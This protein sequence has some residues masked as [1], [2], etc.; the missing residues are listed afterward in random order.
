[1]LIA[2]GE[3]GGPAAVVHWVHGGGHL[4][5]GWLHPAEGYWAAHPGTIYPAAIW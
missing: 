5:H 2:G 3:V 1:M 4:W